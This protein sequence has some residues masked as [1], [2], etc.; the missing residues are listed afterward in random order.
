MRLATRPWRPKEASLR[1][2]VAADSQTWWSVAILERMLVAVSRRSPSDIRWSIRSCL[3]VVTGGRPLRGRSVKPPVSAIR[4]Q[5]FVTAFRDTPIAR[6]ISVTD[7]PCRRRRTMSCR[8]YGC[9]KRI[10]KH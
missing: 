8:W 1:L 10:L 4:L 7:S 9:S 2:T 6:A 3:A 5:A